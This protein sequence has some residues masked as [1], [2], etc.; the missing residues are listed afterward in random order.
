MLNLIK[1]FYLLIIPIFVTPFSLEMLNTKPRIRPVEHEIHVT[2]KIELK[3]PFSKIDGVFSQ[4][5]SNP[6]KKISW[7]QTI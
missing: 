2:T 7:Q 3:S 6:K 1:V 5:G 4:I